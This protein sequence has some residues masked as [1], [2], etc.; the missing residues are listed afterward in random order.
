MSKY[1]FGIDLGTTNSLATYIDDNG[2]IEFVKNEYG[3]ILIP[4]VVGIDEN[5][6]IIVGELAKERRMM[7]AGET[8]SNFKRRMGMRY[9]MAY[10]FYFS[11]CIFTKRYDYYKSNCTLF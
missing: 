9:L 2:K 11:S 8:A 4:S 6:D 7:N 3:N 1:V 10:A 5:D